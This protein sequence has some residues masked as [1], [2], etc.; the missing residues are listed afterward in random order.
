MSSQGV[1]NLTNECVFNL[2]LVYNYDSKVHYQ[3][4]LI[5]ICVKEKGEDMWF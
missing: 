2:K 5:R 3:D 1:N 4:E